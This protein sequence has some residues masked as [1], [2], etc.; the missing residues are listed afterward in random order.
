[1][2]CAF[3]L[4]KPVALLERMELSQQLLSFGFQGGTSR[5]EKLVGFLVSQDVGRIE[6]LI[7]IACIPSSGCSHRHTLQAGQLWLGLRVL[8][9]SLKVILPL[10]TRFVGCGSPAHALF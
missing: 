10:L 3:V 2:L 8:V 7:G 6:D 1:M 4:F 9:L 5:L